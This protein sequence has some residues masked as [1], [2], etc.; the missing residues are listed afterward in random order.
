M[1]KVNRI[2]KIRLSDAVCPDGSGPVLEFPSAAMISKIMKNNGALHT[3]IG[4]ENNYE[5][6]EM[7]LLNF[8]LSNGSRST[9]EDTWYTHMIPK[10]VLKKIRSVTIHYYTYI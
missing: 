3:L 1:K 9:Q 10:N 5:D 8:I 4:F 7:Y 6:G 2:R